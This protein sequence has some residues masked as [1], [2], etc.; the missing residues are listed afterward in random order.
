MKKPRR[1]LLA[2]ASVLTLATGMLLT[3]CKTNKTE[4]VYKDIGDGHFLLDQDVYYVVAGRKIPFAGRYD[5]E[6]SA[7]PKYTVTSSD[8][9]AIA[10]AADGAVIAAKAGDFTLSVREEI[11]GTTATARLVVVGDITQNIMVSVPV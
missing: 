6:T 9:E 8:P 10:V 11:Y 1:I 5:F 3:A 2:L 7:T 4:K